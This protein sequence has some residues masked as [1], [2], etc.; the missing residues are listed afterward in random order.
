MP[1]PQNDPFKNDGRTSINYPLKQQRLDKCFPPVFYLKPVSLWKHMKSSK[2]QFDIIEYASIFRKNEYNFWFMY[3]K[4][5]DLWEIDNFSW[6]HGYLNTFKF[7]PSC[8]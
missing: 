8:D 1:F 2:R 4:Q 3:E 6:M 7:S 5:L